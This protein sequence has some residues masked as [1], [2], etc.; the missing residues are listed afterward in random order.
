VA[1]DERDV[2]FEAAAVQRVRAL[3]DITKE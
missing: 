2:V 3:G 1:V